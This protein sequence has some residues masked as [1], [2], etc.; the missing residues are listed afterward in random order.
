LTDAQIDT[1]V[2]EGGTLDAGSYMEPKRKAILVLA[3]NG[4]RFGPI[5]SSASDAGT[6]Q[7]KVQQRA[8]DNFLARTHQIVKL[9]A[10]PLTLQKRTI[11]GAKLA[12]AGEISFGTAKGSAERQKE[13]NIVKTARHARNVLREYKKSP[14]YRAVQL[15]RMAAARKAKSAQAVT[16]DKPRHETVIA[17]DALE[18]IR[19]EFGGNGDESEH[20]GVDSQRTALSDCS[21]DRS[22]GSINGDGD[23]SHSLNVQN[24]TPCQD[25]TPPI[26]TERAERC[27]FGSTRSKPP[28]GR[29]CVS[30]GR[31][32]MDGAAL[33]EQVQDVPVN[34][35]Q[36]RTTGR[37]LESSRVRREATLDDSG[38]RCSNSLPP[39]VPS[40]MRPH[41]PKPS[42]PKASAFDAQQR[43]A[44]M[45][46]VVA[47]GLRAD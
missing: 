15:A 16:N 14:A 10:T 21:T 47:P 29:R 24:I 22:E 36:S 20:D 2:Q 17:S 46:A 12:T 18:K 41:S 11:N 25:I 23:D 13:K 44:S 5:A 34:P 1:A 3:E 43:W 27:G 4:A 32:A 26:T 33:L 35:L 31:R 37:T 40:R 7:R 38:V 39:P 8:V 42:S 28:S 45:G 19:S 30:M 6:L 9:E